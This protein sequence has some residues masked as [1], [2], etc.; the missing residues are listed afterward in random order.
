M[1]SEMSEKHDFRS[2]L[3]HLTSSNVN[4]VILG[5]LPFVRTAWSDWPVHKWN[6]SVLA[7]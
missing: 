4:L 1:T 2:V 7:N 3:L 6:A 5:S